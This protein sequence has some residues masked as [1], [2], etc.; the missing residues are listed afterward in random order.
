L[1]NENVHPYSLPL[2]LNRAIQSHAAKAFEQGRLFSFKIVN[3]LPTWIAHDLSSFEYALEACLGKQ[4][5]KSRSREM[6]VI[7]SFS[8]LPDGKIELEFTASD[9]PGY[10]LSSDAKPFFTYSMRPYSERETFKHLLP[11][12]TDEATEIKL[13]GEILSGFCVLIVDDSEEALTYA[14]RLVEKFGGKSCCA[15]TGQEAIDKALSEH[16]DVVL[17]DIK[18]PNVDG[19]TA[20]KTLVDQRYRMPVVAVSGFSSKEERKHSLSHGFA[21]YLSKP[22]VPEQLIRTIARLTNRSLPLVHSAPTVPLGTPP[23]PA[24]ASTTKQQPASY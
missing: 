2:A 18:M 16:F 4:L 8:R 17:M 22:I 10:K 15:R 21:D 19:N 5:E 24:S 9:L 11:L 13:A 12:A 20:M 7:C 3:G 23:P 1:E 14:S 6:Y